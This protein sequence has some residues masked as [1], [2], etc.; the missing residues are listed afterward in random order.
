M[1]YG[2]SPGFTL[3]SATTSIGWFGKGVSYHRKSSNT[4]VL[5]YTAVVRELPT[6]VYDKSKDE[7]HERRAKSR[8]KR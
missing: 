3:A 7:V 2:P 6:S 1:L 5:G 4:K 8:F